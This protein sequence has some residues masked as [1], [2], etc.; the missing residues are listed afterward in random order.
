[1]LPLLPLLN[2][3]DDEI[4]AQSARVLG[5]CRC[6][7]AL[8]ELIDK[9]ADPSL[10][11]R[12]FAAQGL[13]RLGSRQAFAPIVELLRELADQDAFLR[14][15]G[16]MGLAG[17]GDIES[18]VRTGLDP[19]PSVRLAALLALRQLKRP[20]VASFLEDSDPAL[21]LEAAR[22][23]HDV[24]ITEALPA[25]AALATPPRFPESVAS[26]V[27]DANF[28]L[29]TPESAAALAQLAFSPLPSEPS[30]VAALTALAD[31]EKCTGKDRILGLWRPLPARDRQ[32]AAAAL[33]P[34]ASWLARQ[35]SPR[36]SAA[37]L[38]AAAVLGIRELNDNLL[39]FLQNSEVDSCLRAA[40]LRGLAEH[41]ADAP[42]REAVTVALDSPA[43]VLRCQAIRLIGRARL[44]DAR[45]RLG[46]LVAPTESLRIRQAAMTAL[47]DLQEEVA[48]TILLPLL[49]QAS[50]DPIGVPAALHLDLL[51]GAGHS[52]SPA[53]SR[54]AQR[55]RAA[56]PAD[57]PLA[58]WWET[59]EGGDPTAGRKIFF[60]KNAVGC[61]RC[62]KVDDI[63]GEVGPSLSAVGSAHPRRYLLESIVFPNAVIAKGYDQ[64]TLVLDDG[65]SV[66]GRVQNE[67]AG[68]MELMLPNGQRRKIAKT[69]V[70]ERAHGKSAMPENLVQLLTKRELRDLV[71]YLAQLRNGPEP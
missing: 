41:T 58:P 60:E 54:A 64:T 20:E 56:R 65:T 6:V 40:A 3:S 28:R 19:S 50:A 68:F 13:G 46:R 25:L 16:V 35:P 31:W 5:D 33:R 4:R 63:G 12:Y 1:L 71:E 21:V 42:L 26:R 30:R 49:E 51:E 39:E 23:I 18:L 47:A 69:A 29:G 66:V 10:R 61:V 48:N 53:V 8:H 22:A 2:D 67:S 7:K 27:I 57:D 45:A 37:A 59:L 36:V 55:L 9:L 52:T 70:Q 43:E 32:T 15:A 24:P 38:Q 44:P 14:H 34:V 11:V 17:I 62:H